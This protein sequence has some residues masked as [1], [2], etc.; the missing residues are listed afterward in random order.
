MMKQTMKLHILFAL[1]CI[2]GLVGCNNVPQTNNASYTTYSDVVVASSLSNQQI[3]CMAQDSDGYIW[4]GTYRGLDRYNGHEMRQYF[5]DDSPNGLPDNQIRSLFSDSKGHLWVATKS[6]VA[7]YTDRDDF[8]HVNMSLNGAF[9]SHIIENSRGD[10]YALQGG[11]IMHYDSL[12]NSLQNIVSGAIPSTDLVRNAFVDI[13]DKFWIVGHSQISC[14]STITLKHIETLNFSANEIGVATLIDNNI[15]MVRNGKI[16]LYN[17]ISHQWQPTPQCIAN[18]HRL[19]NA[20]IS[21]ISV[22]PH[23]NIIIG[24]ASGLFAYSPETDK[25]IHQSEP[26]FPFEAPSF[27]VSL[28]YP[29][30]YGNL[31]FCSSTQG[32]MVS[33]HDRKLFNADSYLRSTFSEKPMASVAYGSDNMLWLATRN[34]GLFGYNISTRTITQY[35]LSTIVPNLNS[36]RIIYIFSDSK[37]DLWLSSLPGGIIHLHHSNGKL[38]YAGS[39]PIDYAIV[40][41]EDAHNT[42][43]VGCYGNTYYSKRTTSNQFEAHRIFGNTFYYMS[44]MAPLS[45]GRFATLVKNYGLR[46]INDSTQQLDV[47]AIPDSTLATCIKRSMFL[48]SAIHEDKNGNLWIGT[49]TN[50]LLRY[51]M[52]SGT[53][54][55]IGGMPCDDI[56]SIEEDQQGNLWVSTQYGLAK[57]V[58]STNSTV[59]YYMSDGIGGNEFYDRA[60]CQLPDGTLIFGGAHGLTV[61]NPQ[62]LTD[63]PETRLHLEDLKVHNKLVRPSDDGCIT[64]S[65]TNA[66]EINIDYTQNS[67][68][69]SFSALDFGGDERFCYQYK[70]DGFNTDWIDAHS[71]REAFYANLHP[72]KYTFNVRVTNKDRTHVIAQRSVVVNVIPAPWNTWWAKLIYAA[73]L[74]SLIV[75]VARL[76]IRLK[77]EHWTLLQAERDREH[78]KRINKMNMSFFA[79]VSHEFRTPLTIIA[80]PVSQ[81]ANDASLSSEQ[82]SLL[83]IVQSSVNRMLRLV[84]QMMD[85]HKLEDDALRLEVVRHDIISLLRQSVAMFSVQAKEKEL[86]ITTQGL[87][88]NCLIWLDADKLDKIVCNLLGNAVKYTPQGGRIDFSFDVVTRQAA[89]DEFPNLPNDDCS[90]YVKIAVAN[91][92]VGIPQ[93]E[94]TRI[95]ERYYQIN[96]Q[97]QGQFNWGTGIGL[98]YAQRLV[99]LHHGRINVQNTADGVMFS[100]VLPA[101][102][103]VYSDAEKAQVGTPSQSSLYPLIDT[104]EETPATPQQADNKRTIMVIDDDVEIVHY[105]KTM[106]SPTYNVLGRFNVD[107]ALESIREKAP[108]LILCDVM[109]Q[110]KDGFE[111]CQEV[112]NDLQLCHIPVI[113]V[114]ARTTTT[115]QIKGLGSGADAYVTK[116]FDPAYLQALINSI[117]Q[118][119]DKVRHI[120]GS[121]TQTDTLETD[122][123][124]PQDNAFMTELY[125]IMEAELSNSDLDVS[126]MTDM[127]RISRTKLYYKVKGLTGENPSAFFRRYK[128]NRAAELIKEGR[129]NM[130]E[131]ADLTGFSSL[132]HFSTSFKKQFG[133]APSEYK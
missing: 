94:L 99:T 6:G 70:L 117:M 78:E 8:M 65:L 21:C 90:R 82:R 119:R 56:C 112:K 115:D 36:Y 132:S 53:L 5:C 69:I 60:S 33:T 2:C 45:N 87:E 61:F 48:P 114:T 89:L 101:A 16:C 3:M 52:N 108:D 130:S 31:W 54:D 81:L 98:Y 51:N 20:S 96:K 39:Y 97:S 86:T 66:K 40:I 67:F 30:T 15:W 85:F 29:D 93:G 118:N 38:S 73:I 47:P 50:G 133:I 121:S 35:D 127:L 103:N 18:E 102:D 10:I 44:C 131:I 109:M 7:I 25:L 43:W 62:S 128:L 129:Y 12:Q 41:N 32:Y 79:N 19:H 64:T 110:G 28:T 100:F 80:G 14:Y 24:T 23:G 120:L 124:S 76:F 92:G 49:V 104:I 59:N 26:D 37:G 42:I 68:S 116:P 75:F 83:K 58:P 105:V 46:Y 72:C 17:V 57:Y 4:F 122:T 126:H 1:S 113:L 34:D 125:K 107:S 77:L 9:V 84:N 63:Y 91:T 123:L 13:E 22:V 27:N 111:L 88:D 74:V 106:L 11:D 71:A 95:F 55:A